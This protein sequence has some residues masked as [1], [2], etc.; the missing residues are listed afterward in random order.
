V[1]RNRFFP[2]I[3]IYFSIVMALGLNSYLLMGSQGL[4]HN[5]GCPPPPPPN[6][7]SH[8]WGVGGGASLLGNRGG[9]N[10]FPRFL[11]RSSLPRIGR[12]GGGA[13]IPG[14]FGGSFSGYMAIRP[15]SHPFGGMRK[16]SIESLVGPLQ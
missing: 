12:E 8:V 1:S 14:F 5:N 6:P 13:V 3:L 10:P 15:H 11:P 16:S 4:L 7:D 9:E 2:I